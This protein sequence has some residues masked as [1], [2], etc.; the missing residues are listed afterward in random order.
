MS[1][2]ECIAGSLDV[3][4]PKGTVEKIGGL[5]TYIAKSSAPGS[6][7]VVLLT[8]VFGFSLVN[9]RLIADAM[10]A[11]G[12]DVYIPDVFEGDHVPHHYLG[13]MTDPSPSFLG[14]IGQGFMLIGQLVGLIS[15]VGR[16]K[17]EKRV[18]LIHSHI[19]ALRK[20]KG[21]TKLGTI[22]YCWGGRHA[23][24]LGATDL[25][26]CY[27]AC[28]PSALK[29]Y[30]DFPPI[31]K[32]GLFALAEG[33][34]GFTASQVAQARATLDPKSDKF[35]TVWRT[36]TGVFHGFASRGRRSDPHIS[37][38]RDEALSAAVDFFKK[39]LA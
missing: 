7:S 22:G 14:R 16:H 12:I 23:V 21:V 24:L 31:K 2:P 20:E 4:E 6:Q 17:D 29:V 5:D 3:G 39:H 10:A 37:K 36:W 8:D 11:K 34:F 1:C 15:F 19:E 18:P 28:H 33:D 13:L 26:D 30:K 38:A 32:P 25:V 27:V 35:E 9:I